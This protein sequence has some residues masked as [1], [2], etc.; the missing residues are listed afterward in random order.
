MDLLARVQRDVQ[1]ALAVKDKIEKYL[2]LLERLEP[3]F[4]RLAP[5]E[6]AK[7]AEIKEKVG[8]ILGDLEE[9]VADYKARKG[10]STAPASGKLG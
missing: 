3:I 8:P 4:K 7:L 2:P 1:V 10:G 9:I 5:E 6:F